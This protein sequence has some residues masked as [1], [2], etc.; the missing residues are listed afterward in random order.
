MTNENTE[1]EASSKETQKSITPVSKEKFDWR[2]LNTLAVVSLASALSGLASLPAIVTG[3][4]ALAQI[5]RSGENGRTLAIIGTV[6]GYLGIALAV[7]FTIGAI[8]YS[9]RMGLDGTELHRGFG[10]MSEL[11]RGFG[12]RR[13]S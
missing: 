8:A 12:F 5:K 13:G 6:L 2:S 10:D 1:D 4:I 3:H 11:H 7:L 9:A